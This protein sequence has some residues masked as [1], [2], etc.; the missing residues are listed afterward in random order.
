M[1]ENRQT[2]MDRHQ[3]KTSKKKFS[4]KKLGKYA[5]IAILIVG[6]SIGGLFTY[7]IATAPELDIDKLQ[8]PFSSEIY[9]KD[10][11]LV[12]DL[13]SEQRK[14]VSYDELPDILIDAVLATEDN[15]FFNHIGID[16]RRIGGAILANITRGFGAEGAST[17]TQQVVENSFLTADKKLKRKV[18]E[19]WLSLKLEREYSKEEI[20]EMYL[21][22]IYYGSGAYGVGKAAEIYF[23]KTNLQDLTLVEAAIL[24]GLPQRPSAYDPYENPDLTEQRLNTVLKLMVRHGKISE[25]EAE[26]AKEIDISSLLAGKK[27]KNGTPYEAFIQQVR[28]EIHTK[29]DDTNLYS[30][31]LK[32]YTT[33]D[34]KAQSYVESL[35]ND[36]E[37]NL[38]D[39]VNDELQAGMTVLDTKTGGILA[40]GGGRNRDNTDSYNYAIQAKRQPGSTFKPLI[41]FGPA[42]EYNKISTYHQLND[43]KPYEVAGTNPIRNV[44]RQY[45]GWVSARTALSSS[46]NVPTVKLMDEIGKENNYSQSKE[47]AEKLGIEFA[48][49]P[50]NIR[51]AIGGHKTDVTPLQLAGAFRPF[52]NEG[53]YNEP[54]AVTKVVYPNGKEVDLTPEAEEVMADYTAYMV[55]DML[56][57]V[58]TH[59][60]GA[61][62]ANIPNLPVA[63]KTGTTNLPDDL[64]GGANNSWFVGYT[65]NYTISVWTGYEKSNQPLIEGQRSIAQTLFKHTMTELSKDVETADFKK[66]NSVVEVA[67]ERGTNPPQL[68][69]KYTPSENI[70]TELFVKGHE[71]SETSERFDELDPVSNLK[72]S[73]DNET[74]M[75]SV[76]WDYNENAIFEVSASVNGGS[77]N[78]LSTTEDNSFEISNVELGAE[79]EIQVVAI[80][81]EDSSNRSEAKT[82]IIKLPDI[83]EN[84]ENNYNNEEPDPDLIAV[85]NLNAQFDETNNTINVSWTYDGPPAQF[86]IS[87]NGEQN[88]IASNNFQITNVESDTNYTIIVKPVGAEGT[89][90][91]KEGPEK[92]TEIY[93]SPPDENNDNN[94]NINANT[95]EQEQSETNNEI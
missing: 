5:L 70:I 38:V 25:K 76:T 3:K 83:E 57:D 50:I 21:N 73:F 16:F 11:N 64:G 56:K 79:Y 48:E 36:K 42:I 51:E 34:P 2:R 85:D 47:F 29:L 67:I 40:I 28:E 72:A 84:D 44:D 10:G 69:S 7:Y 13:G 45:R 8:D 37:N 39:Y 63:G 6:L 24:A 89:N 31:G 33:L 53:I 54:F 95:N 82:T 22:K 9:D 88:T 60:T 4:W 94:N 71:P 62:Y 20:L 86:I 35:L 26:E 74:E 93:I 68:P 32:V 58:L 17:I 75:I 1:T 65:T 80:D 15:R 90:E 87:V 92:S 14:K 30:D 77:M 91:G 18:Q 19:Q 49:D 41:V 61:T 52:G 55:T 81:L 59:G 78:N 66:P 46:I 12:T 27:N 43:D 23:G